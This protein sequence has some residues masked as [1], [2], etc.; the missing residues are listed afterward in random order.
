[1]N[2]F[3]FI[4]LLKPLLLTSQPSPDL[5]T[6]VYECD[7]GT[8]VVANIESSSEE[9]ELTLFLPEET[10]RLSRMT[11][12][13][14]EKFSDGTVTFWTKGNEATLERKGTA[15]RCEENRAASIFEDA[16]LRGVD[17]RGV[18]NEPGWSLE[19]GPDE[20]VFHTSYGEDTY[21]FTTPTPETSDSEPR[22]FYR[23]AEDGHELIVELVGRACADDMS[24]EAFETT[25][26]VTF[27]GTERRGC[28]RPLH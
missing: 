7:D 4:L 21:R 13:S 12:G 14:G 9:S 26:L 19:I 23:V 3:G 24:G 10:L 16:K 28:G 18:G 8:R 15:T 22:S 17:F 1:M 25:V 5:T 20:I 11:S 6:H 27:D 2:V